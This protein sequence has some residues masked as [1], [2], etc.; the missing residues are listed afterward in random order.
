MFEAVPEPERTHPLR[1]IHFQRSDLKRQ[2]S[3]RFRSMFWRTTAAV[4]R[5]RRGDSQ[6]ETVAAA[7]SVENDENC[8]LSETDGWSR[9]SGIGRWSRLFRPGL[10]SST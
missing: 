2:A 4:D 3:N 10:S 5:V 8:L 7:V 6:E 9:A 1:R